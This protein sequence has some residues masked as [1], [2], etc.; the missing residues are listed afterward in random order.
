MWLFLLGYKFNSFIYT[1][2]TRPAKPTKR[3]KGV[4]LS[5]DQKRNSCPGCLQSLPC[6]GNL[7]GYP[8][9]ISIIRLA[10]KWCTKAASYS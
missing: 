4:Q 3:E 7:N 8:Q 5:L 2:Q 6:R 9:T 10:V 1:A